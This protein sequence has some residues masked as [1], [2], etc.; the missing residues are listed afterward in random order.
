M[1]R[2]EIIPSAVVDIGTGI[3][4]SENCVLMIGCGSSQQRCVMVIV[5][6]V[7]RNPCTQKR[8]ESILT[9]VRGCLMKWHATEGWFLRANV[10][11]NGD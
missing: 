6:T 3:D 8:L 4:K 9:T 10:E 11:P 2:C 1:E 7:D 5:F